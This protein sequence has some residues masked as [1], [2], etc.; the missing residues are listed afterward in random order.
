ML[1]DRNAAAVVGDVI[2]L[3]SLCSVTRCSRRSRSSPRRR[4][5]RESPRR[6]GAARRCRRRRCT[7]RALANRLESLEDGDVFCCVVGHEIVSVDPTSVLVSV[8]RSLRRRA[9]VV[10]ARGSCVARARSGLSALGAA[11]L[12]R[13]RGPAAS[14]RSA[15]AGNRTSA[16]SAA[17]SSSTARRHALGVAVHDSTRDVD[18][19]GA[20]S[21]RASVHQSRQR[22][23][24]GSIVVASASIGAGGA[25]APELRAREYAHR[26]LAI[27]LDPQHAFLARG[28]QQI[29]HRGEAV[30]ALVEAFDGGREK[31]LRLPH[32]HRPARRRR[33]LR[34]RLLH[35]AD[36]VLHRHR[37]GRQRSPRPRRSQAC[38]RYAVGLGRVAG[39]EAR[40]HD[41]RRVARRLGA[42]SQF[43]RACDAR[44][45]PSSRDSTSML[46]PACLSVTAPVCA[47]FSMKSRKLPAP[48]SRSENVESSCSSVLLSRPSCGATSRSESTLQRALHQR[49]RLVMSLAPRRPAGRRDRRAACRRRDC[50]RGSRRR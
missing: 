4:R 33:R 18:R 34:E 11:P 50:R 15:V 27:A 8:A 46:R 17:P 29:D 42:A 22:R 12:L 13:R 37:R 48:Y 40:R 35:G 14:H 1:V 2:E 7:C 44:R 45:R 23:H 6:G 43:M 28:A 5:C 36:A 21:D 9:G 38:R 19:L 49:Q 26:A 39:R 16:P 32:V 3:P 25:F 30:L 41:R 31:L 24:T 20:I 10:D 47:T